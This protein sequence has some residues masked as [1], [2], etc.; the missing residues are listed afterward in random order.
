M[1]VICSMT[2][3]ANYKSDG[4]DMQH[5]FLCKLLIRWLWPIAW[6]SVQLS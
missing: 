1:I 6:L 2:F 3:R 5:D 4:C